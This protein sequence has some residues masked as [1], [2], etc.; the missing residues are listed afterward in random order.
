L[1]CLTGEDFNGPDASGTLVPP[2]PGVG[3]FTF[4]G[5]GTPF[6][7][8]SDHYKD[9]VGY[10]F[11][12]QRFN[13]VFRVHEN[14]RFMRSAPVI[15]PDGLTL[16]GVENIKRDNIGAESGSG[17]GGVIFA[18][19][20]GTKV[21]PVS[22][23]PGLY[24][25]PT[26]M[27]DGR[28]ALIGFGQMTVLQGAQVAAK[29]EIPGNSIASAAASRSHVFVSTSDAFLTF[30][31]NTLTE[32]A[33]I[34][35]VGGGKNPPAIGPQGHVYA[36]ASNILFVFP[37]P[38]QQPTGGATVAEPLGGQ[39]V[40]TNS[41]PSPVTPM[42]RE[43]TYKPPM[44]TN[45]NRLFACEELDQDDC[46][47]GDYKTI[48]NAFCEKQGFVDADDTDV[49]SKKVKAE[50][51]DGRFCSKSKCKVFDQIVCKM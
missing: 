28:V 17:T 14:D 40:A 4:A 35:W 20:N 47:K 50:T 15:L 27:A 3:I 38:K 26:R 48:A 43:K 39:P 16:I 21:P 18:G 33:R 25:A 51:L 23:L 36:I 24:V 31:T 41:E 5:G 7:L 19:P 30:D 34:D 49:D 37:P 2:P 32:V 13:E 11:S 42:P 10:T 44:T 12:G 46:G 9:L 22:G 29:L 45:G 6:V 8:A 1:A